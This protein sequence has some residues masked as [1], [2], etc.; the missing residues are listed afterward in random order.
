MFSQRDAEPT[1]WTA[2]EWNRLGKRQP[3][4]R[5][6]EAGCVRK[7]RSLTWSVRML[8]SGVRKLQQQVDVSWAAER[9]R[10][11]CCCH[12]KASSP[13]P[14]RL[15]LFA[16]LSAHL[17][18]SSS[19]E[20][21]FWSAADIE[22]KN[23][24]SLLNMFCRIRFWRFYWRTKSKL[25]DPTGCRHTFS[26]NDSDHHS[27]SARW[28]SGLWLDHFCTLILAFSLFLLMTQFDERFTD[29]LKPKR[30][31]ESL[32][33]LEF[34]LLEWA[35]KLSGVYEVISCLGTP[36]IK[37]PKEQIINI[38]SKNAKVIQEHSI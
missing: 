3:D 14:L 8:S 32:L 15:P 10:A 27:I 31:C 6:V 26:S 25:H 19:S 29:L 16:P 36:L 38:D 23:L 20:L 1:G 11:D 9:R 2:A 13:L 21:E 28:T 5:Q 30:W 37:N 7:R 18:C 22:F 33:N 34:I 4:S 35:R 17:V 12:C 24:L